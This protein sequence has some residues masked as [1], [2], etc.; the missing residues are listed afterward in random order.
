[1]PLSFCS[2]STFRESLQQLC[3]KEKAGYQGCKNDICSFFKDHP[4]DEIWEMKT[5]LK[6]MNNLRL[7]KLRLKNS[8]Q[9]LSAADGY[10]LVICCNRKYQTIAFLNIFPKRGKLGRLDQTTEEYKNQLETYL[11]ALKTH[12]LIFHDIRKELHTVQA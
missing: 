5:L 2:I 4:F 8:S 12:D 3:K 11:S 7:I 10:R 9:N 6:D 1:M